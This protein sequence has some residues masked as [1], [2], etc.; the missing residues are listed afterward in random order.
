[1]ISSGRR[2]FFLQYGKVGKPSC[3][4]LF[5][6]FGYINKAF[7]HISKDFVYISEGFGQRFSGRIIYFC[8]LSGKFFPARKKTIDRR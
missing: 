4:S 8:R 6:G 1:M 5:K 2:K 7:E 3:N